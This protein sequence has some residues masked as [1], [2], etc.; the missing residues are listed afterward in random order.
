LLVKKKI[1]IFILGLSEEIKN[2]VDFIIISRVAQ[3]LD[4]NIIHKFFSKFPLL[5]VHDK[6]SV[7]GDPLTE[8]GEYENL[9]FHGLQSAPN[10]VNVTF[11]FFSKFS[12]K[13]TTL[14]LL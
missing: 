11:V 7:A 14:F 5:S 10:K 12:Q 13:N 9:P 6:S 4:L 1:A 8:P 3:E 2:L